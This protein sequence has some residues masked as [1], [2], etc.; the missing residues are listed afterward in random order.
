MIMLNL[1]G[2]KII[3][4][5]RGSTYVVRTRYNSLLKPRLLDFIRNFPMLAEAA[6][7]YY[8]TNNF[9]LITKRCTVL[10]YILL[11]SSDYSTNN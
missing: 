2:L 8:H 1:N 11:L 4:E 3:A 7:T 5:T 9:D 6:R 10:S